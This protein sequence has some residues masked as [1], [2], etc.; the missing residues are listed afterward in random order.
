MTASPA[1]FDV[2]TGNDAVLTLTTN[3]RPV[4]AGTSITFLNLGAHLS[5][6]GGNGST[7]ALSQGSHTHVITFRPVAIGPACSIQANATV[8]L[9]DPQFNG[10]QSLQSAFSFTA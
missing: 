10:V 3:Y 1:A 4:F 5:I 2:T 6:V 8:S 7:V 9:S